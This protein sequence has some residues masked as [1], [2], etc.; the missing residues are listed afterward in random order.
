MKKTFLLASAVA[1]MIASD[2]AAQ[3]LTVC[4]SWSNFR[5]ERWKTD[6]AAIVGALEAAG[7]CGCSNIGNKAAC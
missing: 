2:V 4:V 5:E 3:D 1:A 6:E 7:F